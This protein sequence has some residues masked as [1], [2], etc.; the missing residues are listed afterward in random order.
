MNI[1]VVAV[2]KL[3]EKYW[4][5][6]NQEYEKRLSAYAK[7]KIVEVA[8]E[9]TPDNPSAAQAEAIKAKEAVRILAQIK[10]RDYV[11]ALAIEG[12]AFTSEAWAEYF[13]RTASQGYSSFVFV[14]GGSLGLHRSVLERANLQLSFSKFT[15]PHQMMRVILLE[16]IYRGF[17]ILRGEKY[18]K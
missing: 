9:P 2:G 16:Q 10:E 11:V 15:F 12:Q 4:V 6:A 8:D 3:K 7:V 17:R 18:H 14:I 13:G 1:T 5:L